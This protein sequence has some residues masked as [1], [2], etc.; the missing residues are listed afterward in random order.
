MI[1]WNNLIYQKLQHRRI[2][3][4]ITKSPSTLVVESLAPSSIYEWMLRFANR[5]QLLR[6]LLSEYLDWQWLHNTVGELHNELMDRL[7]RGESVNCGRDWR[8]RLTV[9]VQVG[10]RVATT[11]EFTVDLGGYQS[12]AWPQIFIRRTWIKAQISSASSVGN[13]NNI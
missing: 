1:K 10:K 8:C 11:T 9:D 12:S 6:G 4:F 5:F 3:R 13:C 2:K 7:D